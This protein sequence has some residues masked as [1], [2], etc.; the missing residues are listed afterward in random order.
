MSDAPMDPYDIRRSRC[1]LDQSSNV[2]VP[3][4]LLLGAPAELQ[5]RYAADHED[6]RAFLADYGALAAKEAPSP[7]EREALAA[8]ADALREAHTAG[9]RLELATILAY[10]ARYLRG[11]HPLRPVQALPRFEMG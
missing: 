6:I 2:N 9:R 11:N 1:M 10:A 5:A 4:H 3:L 8:R 7:E